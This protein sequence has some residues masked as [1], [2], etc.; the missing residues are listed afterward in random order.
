MD[1]NALRQRLLNDYQR[2]FPLDSQPFA[3]IGE[4]LGVDEATVIETFAALAADG[5]IGRI[6]VVIRP[7]TIGASTLA[8]M[9]VPAAR[10][11]EVAARVSRRPEI[12]HCYEREH[13]INLWFVV[14]AGDRATVARVLQEL[15][16]ETGLA[17]LDLPMV[18]E[19]HIDLGFRLP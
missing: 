6:G 15:E 10:L 8:A 11:D 2:D 3:R 19:Y 7:N 9:E 14:T 4:D 17:I 18:T 12:N 16:D 5:L 1:G 13:D